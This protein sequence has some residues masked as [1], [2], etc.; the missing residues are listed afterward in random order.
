M[1]LSFFSKVLSIGEDS[2]MNIYSIDTPSINQKS[3]K[4][5]GKIDLDN[6]QYAIASNS[7]D[8]F[9]IGG[10]QNKVDIHTIADSKK[11]SSEN[12][13]EPYLAMQF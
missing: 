10:E 8:K 12:L 3:L 4:N 6:E 2:I 9:A 7:I 11:I 13:R 1:K 5:I